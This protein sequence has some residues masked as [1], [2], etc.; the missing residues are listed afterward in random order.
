MKKKKNPFPFKLKELHQHVV[1]M[2]VTPSHLCKIKG[3]DLDF[4]KGKR[5]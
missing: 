2:I 5:A 1:F 3:I 4:F